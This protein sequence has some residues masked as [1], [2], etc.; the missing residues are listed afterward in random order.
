MLFEVLSFTAIL[1]YEVTI[2]YLVI[3]TIEDRTR[4]KVKN[5]L[6][7]LSQKPKRDYQQIKEELI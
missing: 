6:Q 5:Q 3:D 1:V 7:N 4:K 2:I